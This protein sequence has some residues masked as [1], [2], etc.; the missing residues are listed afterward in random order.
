MYVPASDIKKLTKAQ[1]LKVD[2]IIMD[3]EDGV[4]ISKKVSDHFIIFLLQILF[5]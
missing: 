1:H 2:C 4:A 3:C 5:F